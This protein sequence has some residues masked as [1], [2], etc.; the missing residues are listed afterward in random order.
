MKTTPGN[1][2]VTLISLVAAM[3]VSLAAA[4]PPAAPARGEVR[5]APPPLARLAGSMADADPIQRWDFT[6]TLLAV[7][8]EAYRDE[9]AASYLERA[10]DGRR[11]AR[12]PRWQAATAAIVDDLTNARRALGNGAEPRVQVDGT[13]QILLFIDRQP[14]VFSPPRPGTETALM[15]LATVRYC[16][17][18]PCDVVLA[19]PFDPFTSPPTNGA[20]SLRQGMLPVYAVGDRLYCTFADLAQR[21]AKGE[22]CEAAANEIARLGK[23]VDAARRQGVV[24]DRDWLAEHPPHQAPDTVVRLNTR[25]RYLRLSLPLLSRLST[26]DWRRVVD[27]LALDDGPAAAPA[28]VIEDGDSLLGPSDRG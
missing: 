9:L 24:I 28:I 13:G 19:E 6:D 18:H 4:A 3:T 14:V 23:A 21:H 1:A 11:A 10:G 7:L 15:E 5:L 27:V 17:H 20:W 8:Q 12:L 25:G 22:R 16:R 26:D 2:V